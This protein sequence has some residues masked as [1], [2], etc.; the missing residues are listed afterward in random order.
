MQRRDSASNRARDANTRLPSVRDEFDEFLKSL[1][2]WHQKVLRDGL[3]SLSVDELQCWQNCDLTVLED[4]ERKYRDLLQRESPELEKQYRMDRRREWDELG[5]FLGQIPPP[6][7]VGRPRSRE[8]L[9]EEAA[10]LQQQNGNNLAQV[11][12]ML[13]QKH[14]NDP[15][16][17]PVS[18][19]GLRKLLARRGLD[20]TLSP[21]PR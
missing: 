3:S 10:L 21:E 19:D 4:V 18:A 16:Y 1:P 13:N 11:A 5:E 8:G 17:Q 20:N 12:E 7:S 2:L 6:R 9:A 14:R 15:G